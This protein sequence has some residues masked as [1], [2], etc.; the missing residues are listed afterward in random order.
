[1]RI[2]TRARA[3]APKHTRE[4]TRLPLSRFV[5]R[6]LTK[7][8]A[9]NSLAAATRARP[10]HATRHV[11]Q[12][13]TT[14]EEESGARVSPRIAG[15]RIIGGPQLLPK[16]EKRVQNRSSKT[17]STGRTEAVHGINRTQRRRNHSTSPER[18]RK[19][20]TRRSVCSRNEMLN[21]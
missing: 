15:T 12:Q 13:T 4:S 17:A 20:A 11:A 9:E 21:M 18:T 6:E 8:N 19:R 2:H 7:A 16:K 5:R 3:H 14:A 10:S 1:M